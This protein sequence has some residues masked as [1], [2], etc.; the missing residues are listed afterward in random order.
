M[1]GKKAPLPCFPSALSVRGLAGFCRILAMKRIGLLCVLAGMILAPSLW[2]QA[3]AAAP[4]AACLPTT[5]LDE[6]VK[7]LDAAVSGPADQDRTCFR[8]LLMPDAR[9]IPLVK[10]AD[11]SFSPRILTV[12]GWIELVRKRGSAI[13]YERQ[14]KVSSEVYGHLA[15]LW[16]T[17]ETRP[18][19]DGKFDV[20]GINSIQAVND[21]TRWKIQEVLWEAETPSE[22]IPARYLP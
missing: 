4:A 16:S 6:L 17:Y 22:Q 8:A 19:P 11:G 12:D 14:V 2:G 5:T 9:L 1:Q 10:A 18:T 20:R 7:A 21:G 15:H 3:T 13:F